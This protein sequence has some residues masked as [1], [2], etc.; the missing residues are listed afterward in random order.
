MI[1]FDVEETR[2]RVLMGMKRREEYD[3][4]GTMLLLRPLSYGEK[5]LLQSQTLAGL[6]IDIDV[7][8][9][10]ADG[11]MPKQFMNCFGNKMSGEKIAALTLNSAKANAQICSWCI[12]SPDG[13]P[14]FS[15][16]EIQEQFPSE[17][18]SPI[19]DAVRKISGM[20]EEG[21]QAL[22]QFRPESVG[23]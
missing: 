7:R 16:D 9:L 14:L 21:Q 1:E 15:L 17:H 2:K 3:L 10:D 11:D 20:T 18:I 22:Q 12:V 13:K 4:D 23:D 19:A 6:D 5:S 8:Q